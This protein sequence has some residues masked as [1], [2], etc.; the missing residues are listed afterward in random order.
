MPRRKGMKLDQALKLYIA[1]YVVCFA[2]TFLISVPMLVH[3][4][5]QSECLLFISPKVEYGPSAGKR[6]FYSITIEIIIQCLSLF[7]L[8]ILLGLHPFWLRSQLWF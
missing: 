8:V 4:A 3:V 5:P 6:N 7:Q 1:V 2:F